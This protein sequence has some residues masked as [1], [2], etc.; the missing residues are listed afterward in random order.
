MELVMSR[1]EI[2]ATTKRIG[3]ALSKDLENEEHIPVV[4]GIMKGALNFM[5]DLAENIKPYVYTEFIQISSY[6][7]TESTEKVTMSRGIDFK[8][9]GR[10]LVLVEDVVDTGLSMKYLLDYIKEKYHPKRI[11]LVALFDKRSRRK[12]EVKIDYVGKLITEDYFLFGYGLDYIEIGRNLPEV[13][14]I[15]PDEVKALLSKIMKD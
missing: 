7:G 4:V 5:M 15:S 9:D 14:A 11:I 6:A 10:T 12:C 8:V 1:A 13:Y 2:Q 3:E